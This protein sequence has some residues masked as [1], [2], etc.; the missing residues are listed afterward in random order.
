MES[1]DFARAYSQVRAQYSDKA[2]FGL[3][4]QEIAK[5]VYAELETLDLSY[6]KGW[7]KPKFDLD[8]MAAE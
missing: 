1:G 3:S 2:W 5:A 7:Y 4:I 6:S 8:R